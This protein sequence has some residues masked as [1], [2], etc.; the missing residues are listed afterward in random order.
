MPPLEHLPL[1]LL[2]RSPPQGWRCPRGSNTSPATPPFLHLFYHLCKCANTPSVSPSHASV[3]AFSQT[4][5]KGYSL[6]TDSALGLKCNASISTPIGTRWSSCPIR[7]PLLI[8]RSS[9]LNVITLAKCLDH[10]TKKLLSSFTFAL[11]F[12]FFSLSSFSKPSTWSP[13]P[14]PSSTWSSFAPPLG[15]VPPISWSLEQIG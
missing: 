11:S 15:I 7:A 13:W 2:Y 8:A 4:F 3:L 6:L 1:G 5:F 9:I 10:Q 14:L 12:L